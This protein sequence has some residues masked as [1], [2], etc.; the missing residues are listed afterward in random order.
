[1]ERDQLVYQFL[2]DRGIPSAF[3]MAGGYGEYSWKVYA[4]FLEWAL[5][6]RLEPRLSGSGFSAA[7]D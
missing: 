4:Q 5:L 7:S 3:V 2:K 1:L 6:D